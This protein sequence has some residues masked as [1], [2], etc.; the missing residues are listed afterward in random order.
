MSFSLNLSNYV[1]T[2]ATTVVKTE[3]V[4]E[5][6]LLEEVIDRVIKEIDAELVEFQPVEFAFDGLIRQ[7]S[8]GGADSAPGLALH[9]TRAHDVTWKTLVGVKEDLEAFQ[10]SCRD[11]KNQIILAD[12]RSADEQ[13]RTLDAVE[14]IY[15]G[16]SNGQGRRD[17]Q[18]ARQNQDTNPTEPTTD[19]GD[20]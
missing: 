16:A 20:I 19:E 15:A 7:G 5:L 4:R 13:R 18:D 3:A 1:P 8:F 10:Q 11:A 6:V 12:E 9:Y 14:T 17:Y 2:D